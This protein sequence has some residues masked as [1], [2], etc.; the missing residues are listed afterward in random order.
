MQRTFTTTA[1]ATLALAVF[2]PTGIRAQEGGGEPCEECNEPPPVPP[3]PV[4]PW[5]HI[6]PDGPY[7]NIRG[8]NFVPEYASLFSYDIDPDDPVVPPGGEYPPLFLPL[9]DGFMGVA[10]STAMWC[11]YDAVPFTA[12]AG[13]ATSGTATPRDDIKIQL[14]AIRRTGVNTVR[15]GWARRF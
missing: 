11:Y 1:L 7:Q 6:C 15:G 3:P 5:E 12:Q 13:Y 2:L 8:F 9:A 4:D 10:S 14:N